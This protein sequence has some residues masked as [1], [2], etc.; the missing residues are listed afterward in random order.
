MDMF[1]ILTFTVLLSFC[2]MYTYKIITLYTLKLHTVLCK[3]YLNKATKTQWL[4]QILL[5]LSS[6]SHTSLLFKWWTDSKTFLFFPL[7]LSGCEILN[8]PRMFSCWFHSLY[9]SSQLPSSCFFLVRPLGVLT[10]YVP[11][12]MWT[13]TV[14]RGPLHRA[15]EVLW[16]AHFS[17]VLCPTHPISLSSPHSDLCISETSVFFL[18]SLAWNTTWKVFKKKAGVIVRPTP[19]FPFSQDVLCFLFTKICIYLFHILPWFPENKA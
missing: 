8:N 10:A 17:L 11:F 7:P 18:E 2:N 1:T 6:D 12:T 16:L 15:Q 5:S 9:Y 4:Q 19:L 3:L 13:K 14:L